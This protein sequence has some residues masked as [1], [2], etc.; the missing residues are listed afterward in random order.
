ME[1]AFVRADA[2]RA[3]A[4]RSRVRLTYDGKSG[5]VYKSTLRLEREI[6][7]AGGAS[8]KLAGGGPSVPTDNPRLVT[9]AVTVPKAHGGVVVHV[10]QDGHLL[11]GTKQRVAVDAVRNL[12]QPDTKTVLYAGVYNGFG[13]V[14][15]AFAARRL[16]LRCVVFVAKLHPGQ[17]SNEVERSRQVS[18][19]KELGAR[20]HL[21]PT[22]AEARR[23]EFEMADADPTCLVLPLGLRDDAGFTVKLLSERMREAAIGVPAVEAARRIW[24][25]SG[26]GGVAAALHAAF[27]AVRI[28]ILPTGGAKHRER[29]RLWAAK[30]AGVQVVREERSLS[31][32]GDVAKYYDSVV[33][34][35][36]KLWPYIKKYGM[37][38]DVVWN[39][40]SDEP[41][42]GSGR[43]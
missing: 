37:A 20:V 31:A 38:G 29:V 16:G 18:T 30:E 9:E 40:A 23:A 36:A 43:R 32:S 13:A 17:A 7:A 25:V 34:Y 26:S 11:A 8:S 19:M 1:A 28:M 24:V 4:R 27:P 2:A 5:R 12:L 3:A 14:A 6:A 41:P 35:D 10:V 22:Y 15:T 39:V 42:R 21:F 33:D